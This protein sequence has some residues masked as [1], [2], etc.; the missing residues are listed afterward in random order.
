MYVTSQFCYWMVRNC[1]NGYKLA[2][3]IPVL[4]VSY[5]LHN[6]SSQDTT[7]ALYLVMTL[8]LISFLFFFTQHVITRISSRVPWYCIVIDQVNKLPGNGL[9]T[10]P[11]TSRYIVNTWI[12]RKK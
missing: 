8:V 12:S 10:S 3:F 7:I 2:G 4:T 1:Q 5:H 6:C 11:E 9:K